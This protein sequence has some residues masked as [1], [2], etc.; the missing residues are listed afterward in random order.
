MEWFEKVLDRHQVNNNEIN[1]HNDLYSL[2]FDWIENDSNRG[3]FKLI[4]VNGNEIKGFMNI[5]KTFKKSSI[6]VLFNNKF[7]IKKRGL[8]NKRIMFYEDNKSPAAV[9]SKKGV[10]TEE[11]LLSNGTKLLWKTSNS[12]NND[13]V[14][15]D[16][17][18]NELLQLN[19]GSAFLKTGFK[20]NI[21]DKKLYQKTVLLLIVIGIFNLINS[22]K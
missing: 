18:E 11:I 15:L 13:W 4:I 16:E 22:N 19:P 17:Y 1:P 14:Y 10:G 3:A 5:N 12:S 7:V 8:F 20:I 2:Q 21:K 9:I 6:C